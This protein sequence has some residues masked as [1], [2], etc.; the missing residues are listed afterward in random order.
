MSVTPSTNL[1]ADLTIRRPVQDT[2]DVCTGGGLQALLCARHSAR[3]VATDLNPRA[4]EYAAF[5]AQLSGIDNVE[6]RR[7]DLFEPV[8]G[9]VFDLV[10]ANPPFIISPDDS[11]AF[12]DSPLEGDEISRHT[13]RGAAEHLREGGFAVVL[14]GWGRAAGQ[15]WSE[16]LRGW[17]EGL[18]CDAWL[19]HH[20]SSDPL[21]Y[22]AGFNRPVAAVDPEGYA[23]AVERWLEYDERL[24]FEAIGYGAVVLRRRSGDNWVRA[25]ALYRQQRE[26]AGEHVARLFDARD[27]LDSLDGP[28]ALLDAV[29][30]TN[31]RHRIEQVLRK[32]DDGY[33]VEAARAVLEDGL[34]FVASLDVNAAQVLVGLDGKRTVRE[35][36]D[37]ARENVHPDITAEQF[38]EAALPVVRRMVELG[39]VLAA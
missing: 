13:V 15:D 26:P 38:Q 5:S 3:V 29:L 17:V 31:E 27:L 23:T 1:L 33:A 7:G 16:P 12:R 2:L 32:R 10:V 30:R 19:L 8:E 21:E 35:V 20:T 34:G 25:D 28:D 39:F 18:G 14:V 6:F 9:E 24:G 22:A 37:D 4:L 36:L 11:Y